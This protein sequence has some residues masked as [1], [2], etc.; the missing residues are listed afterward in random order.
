[1]GAAAEEGGVEANGGAGTRARTRLGACF[2]PSCWSARAFPAS[3]E[4]RAGAGPSRGAR[5][6]RRREVR[7]AGAEDC[8]GRCGCA[9]APRR[10]CAAAPPPAGCV[11]ARARVPAVRARRDAEVKFGREGDRSF[12]ARKPEWPPLL[13]PARRRGQG[14]GEG[15]AAAAGREAGRVTRQWEP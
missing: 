7:A 13:N 15:Q 9:R 5:R 4:T 6:G 14:R 11:A 3:P 8:G 10:G 12:S 2:P 1:M